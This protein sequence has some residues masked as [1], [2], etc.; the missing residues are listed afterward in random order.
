[1]TLRELSMLFNLSCKEASRLASELFDRDL[2]R[3]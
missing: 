1:M 2:S 3:Y